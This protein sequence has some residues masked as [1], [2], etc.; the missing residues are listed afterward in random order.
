MALVLMG[1]DT[2][3]TM[4]T[5]LRNVWQELVRIID[6]DDF[7]IVRQDDANIKF[8]N[9]VHRIA[10]EVTHGTGEHLLCASQMKAQV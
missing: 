6:G 5:V 8:W 9:M 4:M 7:L 2:W 3:R 1:T 10:S